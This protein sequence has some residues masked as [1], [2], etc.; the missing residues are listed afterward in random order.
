MPEKKTPDY[1]NSGMDIP[2]DAIMRIARAMLPMIQHYYETDEGKREL[3]AWNEK[4]KED[5]T[6]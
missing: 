1:K 5:D 4:H 6:I 3:A 2:D